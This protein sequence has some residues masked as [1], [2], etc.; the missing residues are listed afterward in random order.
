[1]D[2]LIIALINKLAGWLVGKAFFARVLAVVSVL[3]GRLDLDGDGKKEAAWTELKN[4]GILFGTKQ[5]N[6]SIELACQLLD[7]KKA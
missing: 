2:T 4:A 7:R 5:F 6:T 1:M 3:D